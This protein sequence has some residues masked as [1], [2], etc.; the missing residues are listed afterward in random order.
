MITLRLAHFNIKRIIRHRDLRLAFVLLP[1]VV[2][3][4]RALFAG[5]RAVLI[6]AEL[7]PIVC[8]LLIGAVLYT[9]WAVDSASGLVTGFRASPISF[10]ALV[11]SRVLSGLSIL[12][13]QMALFGLILAARF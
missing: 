11:V 13:I 4:S 2:A 3:L 1:L 5:N 10:R 12:A 7:C 8:A 9:Q 6:A